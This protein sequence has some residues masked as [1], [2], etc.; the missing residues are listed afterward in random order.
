MKRK[1]IKEEVE[2]IIKNSKNASEAIENLGLP[3]GRYTQ[4]NILIKRFNIDTSHFIKL[5]PNQAKKYTKEECQEIAKKYKHRK[6]FRL[7]D[8]SFYIQAK[9]NGWLDE[10][11]LKEKRELT[12]EI[13]FNIAK[14]FDDYTEFHKKEDAVYCKANSKGWL[15]DYT[16]LK[17][18]KRDFESKINCIYVYEF[19]DF[20]AVYVGRTMNIYRRNYR[21]LHNTN[22]SVYQF[23]INNNIDISSVKYKIIK[24]ELNTQESVEWECFYIDKY[25][26]EEWKLINRAKGGSIGGTVILWTYEKCYEI[27]KQFEYVKDFYDQYPT[28]A[29]KSAK[30]KWMEKFVWLEKFKP[31]H[32]YTYEECLE[33][34]K[35]CKSMYE[36]R[37]YYSSYVSFAQRKNWIK[38]YEWLKIKEKRHIAEYDKNGD[39]IKILDKLPLKNASLIVATA[40]GKHKYMN[41]KIYKYVDDLLKTYNEIPNHIEVDLTPSYVK[42]VVQ[43]DKNG[44]FINEYQKVCDVPFGITDA[45]KGRHKY[46]HN[47][48]WKYKKDV[49]DDNG[50]VLKHIEV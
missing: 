35:L 42:S 46:S 38:D 50:N 9:N 28:V 24:D 3:K 18:D 39:F 17:R 34:A 10:I 32:I 30:M 22:D 6:D 15:K 13:C 25:R 45:L 16:W 12:Y 47:F 11:L 5:I 4:L 21:H 43:Y 1:Y 48:I 14:Q 8:W 7:Y 37:K 26:Q 33:K 44:N 29:N 23:I 2:T 40:R 27:A 36:F 31:K 49:L 20:N 41:D 19:E